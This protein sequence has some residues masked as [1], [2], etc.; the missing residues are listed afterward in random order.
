[1]DHDIKDY[2]YLYE[3]HMHTSQASAC[4]RQPG[5]A[6]AKAAKDAGYA[7]VIVTDHSWYGNHCIDRSL[8]W[9]QWIE[10]FCMGYEDAKRWGDEND[11]SVFFGYESNYGG[12]E[13]LIYGV[14]KEWLIGHPQIKDISIEGQFRLIHEAG[15]L[16]IHAHPY[17]EADYIKE[18]RLF[19]EYVDGVEGVNATHSSTRKTIPLHP[20][21]NECAINYARE[22]G[23]PLTGGSDQHNTEMIM[24]GMVFARKLIDIRDFAGAVIAGEA[25]RI[26]DGTQE[27]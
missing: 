18:I 4:A 9:E 26:P 6:M 5:T 8:P 3:T 19:P 16:V 13:F 10:A 22:H 21:Y 25:V 24:G 27:A 17:R 2:P 11:F 7:G 23:L 12:T 14:D 1:M 15:G 20:E